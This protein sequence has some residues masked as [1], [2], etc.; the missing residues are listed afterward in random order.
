M[1]RSRMPDPSCVAFEPRNG[2]E[3]WLRWER[4]NTRLMDLMGFWPPTT[5]FRLWA[6]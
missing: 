4:L 3:L 6:S 5:R 2:G 1:E